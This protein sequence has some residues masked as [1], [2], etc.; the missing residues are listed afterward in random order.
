ME[1]KRGHRGACDDAEAEPMAKPSRRIAVDSREAASTEA[2]THD[3]SHR[4][5]M[6]VKRSIA[7]VPCFVP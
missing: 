5:A 6:Q 1:L 2:A 4:A 7:F 3:L